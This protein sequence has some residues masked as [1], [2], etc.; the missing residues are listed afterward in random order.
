MSLFPD[1]RQSNSRS[2]RVRIVGDHPHRGESGTVRDD[3]PMKLGMWQVDL[4]DS[5]IGATGCF[6][7]PEHLRSLPAREDPY[8]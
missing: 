2:K 6:A 1:P 3:L 4:D 7:G 8:A 5:H